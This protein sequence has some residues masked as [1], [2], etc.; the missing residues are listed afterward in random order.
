MNVFTFEH[1]SLLQIATVL[2]L[3]AS[4]VGNMILDKPTDLTGEAFVD[5]EPFVDCGAGVEHCSLVPLRVAQVRIEHVLILQ[6]NE[7]IRHLACLV[8]DSFC[9]G[10]S[11]AAI[12]VR[13]CAHCSRSFVYT[14]TRR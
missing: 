3:S 12:N 13:H 11:I 10:I 14:L 8:V 5:P 7:Y 4:V 1:I 6:T 9:W 2:T